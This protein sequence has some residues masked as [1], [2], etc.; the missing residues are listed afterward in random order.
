MLLFV[1]RRAPILRWRFDTGAELRG[2]MPWPAWVVKH[3]AG[4]SDQ[5]RLAAGDDVFRLPRISD[6]A[7]G[8]GV[9]PGRLLYCLR[10]RHLVAGAE[11]DFL[12]RRN[13]AGRR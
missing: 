7:D 13:T 4:E 6:Q 1:R 3:P 8:C 11:R 2:C 9:D 5:I 12:E 10:E